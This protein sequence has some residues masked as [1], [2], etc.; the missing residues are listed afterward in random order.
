MFHGGGGFHG[1]HHGPGGGHFDSDEVLGKVYDSRV[2]GKLP[3]YLAPVKGWIGIGASGMLV[4]TLATLAAP[5]LVGRATDSIVGGE[6]GQMAIIVIFYMLASLLTW[7]G[8]YLESVY[9]AY[10]GQSIIY[11]MRT[12]MFDHLQRLS[13]SFFDSH[14]VGKLMS[15]VQNDVS[16]I[17]E[18]VTQ[19]IL[20]LLTSVLTLLGIAIIMITM[21]PRLAG[22][23]LTVIPVMIIMTVIWQKYAR[24]AF[25]RVRTAIAT[26]N[27]QLQ[28]DMSGVRV[29]QSLSREG[30]NMEQFDQVNRA[31]L[32]ANVTA[33]KFEA[34][35]M[36]MVNFFTGVSFAIVI[37]YGGYQVLD[38]VMSVGV[39]MAFLLYVQR[40]FEPVL[41]LSMQYTE[42]QR[43]MA[44]G[45]RIFELLEVEPDIQDRPDAIELPQ[46]NGEIVF[47]DMSFAYE[48][49]KNVLHDIN[50]TVK[51]G[52]TVAIVGQTGS[53]KSSLVSLTA[54]FY[55]VAEG[56]VT[57]DGHDVRSV[58]IQSLRKQIGIVPQ[59]PILFSGT[60]E[61]NIKFG[62]LDAT[63]EQVVEVTKTVGADHFISRLD[64]GYETPVG[65][66]GVNLSAGQRQLICLARAILA[67]P[68]ILILDEATSNIDTS[69]ERIMQRALRKLTKGR[70]CLTIAHR[71][72]TVTKSDRIIVLEHG[73][74][75]E[76]GSHN[77]LLAK[78][79]LYQKMYETL[80]APGMVA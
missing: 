33:V 37:I 48:E 49:G 26:V 10:A 32:D 69:T 50:L 75:V 30:E 20:T 66:R 4:R 40:F 72:S 14:Q 46:V 8:Q 53:G 38:G 27:S 21:D 58:T 25:I 1:P 3:K 54:R 70:T 76:E 56:S 77:E 68:R 64:K 55:E 28:E 5:Y 51:P 22:I 16:Q 35:M 34:L 79:G 42:L 74:I 41:E 67:D 71:L 78:G 12:Q 44:S 60:I 36:P 9:L 63:H 2:I 17:Q 80:S 11:R 7:G 6:L 23:T 18:L 15:R 52:E 29:I 61:E 31:H 19:G 73:R 24:Q 47:K 65:Q 39:L 45:A 13:L 59:D 43:A 62:R 57:V